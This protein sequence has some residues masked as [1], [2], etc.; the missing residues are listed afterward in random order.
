M[1]DDGVTTMTYLLFL[2]LQGCV[3][4]SLAS[5]VKILVKSLKSPHQNLFMQF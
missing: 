4:Y 3:T 2:A 1:L 5:K